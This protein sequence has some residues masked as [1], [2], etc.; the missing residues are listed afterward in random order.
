MHFTQSIEYN[1]YL[2]AHKSDLNNKHLSVH[3]ENEW[4]I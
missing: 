3:S 4:G 2:F 1:P